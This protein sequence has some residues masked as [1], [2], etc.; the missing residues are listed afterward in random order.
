MNM[1]TESEIAVLL[2]QCAKGI[3]EQNDNTP[4]ASWEPAARFVCHPY[5]AEVIRRAARAAARNWRRWD[6]E[7]DL[8]DEVG[9]CFAE[10][11]ARGVDYKHCC[12]LCL[13][14]WTRAVAYNV[15]RSLLRSERSKVASL[16]SEQLDLLES[17]GRT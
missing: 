14:G 16:S 4:G 15:A 11:L 9:S 12:D 1:D 8:P 2:N 5:V 17:T 10:R 13:Y 6:R 7:D 3:S